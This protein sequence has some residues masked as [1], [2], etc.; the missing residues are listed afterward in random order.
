MRYPTLLLMAVLAAVPPAEAQTRIKVKESARIKEVTA[1]T[2]STAGKTE[3]RV[4]ETEIRYK[5][6]LEE[7]SGP[8]ERAGVSLDQARV[9]ASEPA[10]RVEV[11]RLYNVAIQEASGRLKV[12]ASNS[13]GVYLLQQGD[14]AKA[15]SVLSTVRGDLE[16]SGELEPEARSRFL[17]NY[18]VA[19]EKSG[20]AEEAS[21]AYLKSFEL[22]PGFMPA[23]DAVF[24]TSGSDLQGRV[25]VVERLLEEGSLD[26]ARDYL[27]TSFES[28]T[29]ESYPELVVLWARYLTAA[30]IG[31]GQDIR[32]TV[33]I[34]TDWVDGPA[35]AR[36]GL[37]EK[38]Y[39]GE[40]PLVLDPEQGFLYSSF[41]RD[42][43]GSV[44]VFSNL[45]RML[46]EGFLRA[47]QYQQALHSYALAWSSAANADA[48]VDLASLLLAQREKVDPQG[49]VLDQLV[50]VL[51]EGKG[52]AYQ[53]ND[54]PNVLR[55]HTILGTI[56]ERQGKWGS[57]GEPKSAIFQ[58]ERALRALE[59][60]PAQE[61]TLA[62]GLHAHLGTAYEAVGRK[63]D[64][65]AQFLLAGEQYVK[66]GW[67]E[68]AAAPLRQA[69]ALAPSS[70][71]PEEKERL[72]S[73]KATLAGYSLKKAPTMEPNEPPR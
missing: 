51:F 48:A 28:G 73:L 68:T 31:P 42:G 44:E 4:Q 12:D 3:M 24:R 18:G 22:D 45:L 66:A 16:A 8:Q 36:I 40:L 56:F 10:Q 57:S 21:A 63:E 59:R 1:T 71:K 32:K 20:Q 30:K 27:K 29:P 67:P 64:A 50:S 35:G 17:Y 34:S 61:R 54:W 6:A 43:K 14:A 23:C 55:F 52:G 9:L 49:Q 70:G 53:G 60:L 19:L 41:W 37:I 15:A 39:A 26:S 72:R 7:A 25:R 65:L 62:P 58:W 2:P 5:K 69:E 47:G 13:Y 33:G 46:G 11:E 38:S